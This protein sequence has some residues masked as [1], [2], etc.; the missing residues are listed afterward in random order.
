MS[1][2]MKYFMVVWIMGLCSSCSQTKNQYQ[3]GSYGYDKE[4]FEQNNID[5]LELK[6]GDNLSKLLIVPAYQGR[7]MTSTAGG[8]KGNSYGWINHSFIES[9]KKDPQFNVY[10]GEERF[11]L[12]PEGGPYSIYFNESVEQV[13]EHWVVP[14]VIDTET[15][16]IKEHDSRSIKFTKQTVLKNASGTEFS[17][18]IERTIS[19][20]SREEVSTWLDID[21]PVD[22]QMVAYQTDNV[23]TNQGEHAWTKEGGLLSIWM[24]SMFN[25]SPATTVFIP[26]QTDGEG[27]V[28]N[29]DYFGKVP[30]GRL[31]VDHGTIYFKVDGKCRGKIGLPPSRATSICGSYDSD[32]R[33]LTLLWCTLPSEPQLYVNSKWGEQDDPYRGDVIN[34][35]ND[36]PVAD[37]TIMGPFYEIETS[38]PAAE[39]EPAESMKHVQRL[40]HFQGEEQELTRIVDNLFNLNLNSIA[41]KFQ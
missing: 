11:W 39:L 7:V 14:A 13:Y 8:D 15:Y 31:I 17:L 38:S 5:F 35:Y 29:D 22:L 10:G 24:L 25:P 6:T 30:A 9:G 28:V 4:F 21:I 41:K 36:G 26:Y 23:I 33:V 16:N 27:P 1:H 32:N 2:Y 19:L 3:M 37:G 34:S 40:A 12:G 20:L 18:G